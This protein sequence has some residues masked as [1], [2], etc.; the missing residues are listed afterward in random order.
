M[1]HMWSKIIV[2]QGFALTFLTSAAQTFNGTGGPIPDDGSWF[3]FEIAVSGLPTAIDTLSFGLEQV[4]INVEHTWI[5]DLDITIVAPDGTAALL[6][7]GNGGDQD[8]YTNTCFRADAADVITAGSQP[9]TGDW[10]P[11][12][13]MGVVNNGQD[14]NGTWILRF[15]DTWPFADT[16]ELFNWSI[17]FGSAPATYFTLHDSNLPIVVVNTQSAIPNEPKVPATMGIISNPPG[18][19]N[20]FTDPFTD[21]DGRIGIELRGNSSLVFPKKGYGFELWDANDNDTSVALVGM[22]AE[23]DWVLSA[24]YS[25]KSLL[26]NPLTFHLARRMGHWAP[27]TQHVELVMDGQ[28]I[29]VYILT[30]KIKRDG[31]RVDIAKLDPDDLAGDSLTGGYIVKIDWQQGNNSLSWNSP[32]PP[33]N[34]SGNEVIEFIYDYPSLP[35]PQQQAYIE[36]YIDSFETA[37]IGPQFTHPQLGYAQYIDQRSFIDFMI[38]NE[39]GRNVDGYRLSTFLHKD[40]DSKGG[41]LAMGPLWDFD[42]AWHNADYCYGSEYTGWAYDFNYDCPGGKM[43]PFWWWRLQE[44]TTFTDSLRCRWEELRNGPLHT[45]S[46]LAW[47]DTMAT[48]LGESQQR[49]FQVWPILGTYVWPNPGPL[50]TDYAGE[51]QE[52]KDWLVLRS[53]WLDFNWPQNVG[54]CLHV[55]V[56]GAADVSA[57]EVFPNPFVDRLTVSGAFAARNTAT[58]ELIDALGRSAAHVA[59]GSADGKAMVLDIPPGLPPGTYALRVWDNES[60]RSFTVVKLKP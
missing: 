27:R 33:P 13:Q 30:E 38:V 49:N 6:V 43:V 26:N 5:A 28:Y 54:G 46:L 16:G 18:V 60:V 15:L 10:R 17:S 14:P 4:C 19:R 8:F 56:A 35:E 23:S 44:D 9:Y 50:P 47:C 7:G 55:G 32:Y 3:E 22:P 52:L 41:K 53:A 40:K 24:N 42:L 36:A 57:V 12:Q 21:Y 20:D 34:A 1:E 31:D 25:D 2:L 11:M 48:Y 59:H 58:L 51:I 39:F 29:G 45:D 37:L